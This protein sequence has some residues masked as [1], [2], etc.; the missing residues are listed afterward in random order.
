M[1]G[2]LE[3]LNEANQAKIGVDV[4]VRVQY[5]ETGPSTWLIDIMHLDIDPSH[6]PIDV[7]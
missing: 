6:N 4:C 7:P 1:G 2:K 5:P 3:Q